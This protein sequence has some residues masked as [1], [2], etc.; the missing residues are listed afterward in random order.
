MDKKV[1]YIASTVGTFVGGYIPVIFGA[2]GFSV[3]SVLGGAAGGILAIV[4]VYKVSK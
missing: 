4:V 2:D 3:W 1:Y